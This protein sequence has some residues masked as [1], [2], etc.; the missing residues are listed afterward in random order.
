MTTSIYEISLEDLNFLHRAIALGEAAEAEGNLPI[1]AVIVMDDMV[2]AEAA[3]KILVPEFHPGRHAEIEA[4]NAIPG[5]RLH[6]HSK[7]MTLYTT[8]EPCLMC[9][10]AIVL[11]RIGRVVYGGNDPKR[12]AAYLREHLTRIYDPASL[13]VFIGPVLPEICDP[14]FERA[15]KVYR[16]FR[17]K[18]T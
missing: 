11:Y 1:G 13:P 18:Q 9:F 5:E 12:G 17:D 14:L 4:M 3:N 15:D 10:G 6:G 2:I 16:R 7:N 8:Q